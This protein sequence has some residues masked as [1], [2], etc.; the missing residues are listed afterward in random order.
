MSAVYYAA[1]GRGAACRTHNGG[2]YRGIVLALVLALSAGAAPS[3][4][5]KTAAEHARAG[6]E[7]LNAGRPREAAAAFDEALKIDAQAAAVLLGAG[8]AAHL[9]G[10]S[11]NARRFLVGALSSEPSLTAASLLLGEVLYRSSDIAAAIQ[12]YEQA[13][14]HAPGHR[15][16]SSRLEAWRRE[17]ALHDRFAQTLGD[18]FTVLFEGPA[19]AALGARAVEVL[20]AAYWRIGSALYTYPADVITVVLYTRE[21]FRDVTQAPDWAGGAYDGRIRVPVLGAMRDPG[22]FERV[23]A[24]EFTHALVKSLAPRGVPQWLNEGLAMQFE[25]TDLA[26]LVERARSAGSR[27]ALSNLERPFTGMTASAASLAYAQSAAAVKRLLD[28]TGPAAIVG[29][30]T[31]LARGLPFPE[32][33]SRQTNMTYEEFQLQR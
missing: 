5:R 9:L 19:E 22:E 23:L 27:H 7:A 2:M 21:Q 30:L 17:A 14:V 11:D 33:F 3:G 24:H 16:L 26:P 32:A 25:G 29:I 12:V 28:T 1:G 4:Q 10:Q 6:W 20:E 15:Q 31:D 18:H 8:V 13:L